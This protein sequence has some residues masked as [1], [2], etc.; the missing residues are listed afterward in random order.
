MSDYLMRGD[1]PLSDSEWERLDKTVVSAAREFLVG[2]KFLDLAGPFG[3]GLEM[4]P[5]GTGEN[6]EYIPL[7]VIEQEFTL[8]W[9]EVEASRKME[10]PIPM[11]AAAR[12]S[13]A[14]ARAEDQ[15]ILQ[16]LMDAAA[17]SISLGD[18]EDAGGPL[19]AVSAATEV[20]VENEAFGPYAVVVSPQLFTKTQRVSR[21]YGR[22]VGRLVREVAEGG[23]FRSPLLG[24][25]EGFVL[26]LGSY[27]FDLAVG[28]D[29]ITAYEG[30]EG[31]DHLFKV[32][33]TIAVRV[34]RP[35]AIVTFEA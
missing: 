25:D 29:L 13:L 26:S 4:I 2:R 15:M 20:L 7:T 27:N 18:W 33:E 8:N 14:C 23:L 10:M 34:K 19:A 31:L 17:N 22:T 35:D 28:Q 11:S 3:A 12:A 32:L 9:R 21:G 30:N 16:A 24:E 5:M 6:R 1:A